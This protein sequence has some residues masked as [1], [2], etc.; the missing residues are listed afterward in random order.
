MRED[1][2]RPWSSSKPDASRL[3]NLPLL[4]SKKINRKIENLSPSQNRKPISIEKSKKYFHQK[5]EKIS[6]SQ[7]QKIIISPSKNRKIYPSKNRSHIHKHL[8]VSGII[9]FSTIILFF[10]QIPRAD[11]EADGRAAQGQSAHQ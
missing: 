8:I 5:I 10:L 6:A 3:Q 7:N 11:S 2:T 1:V 4:N 9:L